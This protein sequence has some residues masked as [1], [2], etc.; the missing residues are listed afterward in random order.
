[1]LAAIALAA[2]VAANAP[3]RALAA[4]GTWAAFDRGGQCE[5]LS[6]AP[7]PEAL[8]KPAAIVA[9]TF[10]RAGRRSGQMSVRFRRPLR[11]GS[12]VMLTVGSQ[13]FELVGQGTAAWSRG[14]AQEG[15]ILAALRSSSGARV[16]ARDAA[17]R[18]MTERFLLDGAPTAIDAAAAACA[19]PF[20]RP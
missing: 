6:R 12:S 19:Q 3:P 8:D 15:A 4:R 13:P 2:L 18:R 5:A 11:P 10:D 16:N 14:P 7:L 9:I 17:G 1:M 20:S